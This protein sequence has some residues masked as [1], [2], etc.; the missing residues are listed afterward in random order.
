M[1]FTKQSKFPKD[2]V[3]LLGT[4][5]DG[6]SPKKL[7][8]FFGDGRSVVVKDGMK[9]KVRIVRSH[10]SG[11]LRA[12]GFPYDQDEVYITGVCRSTHSIEVWGHSFQRFC[13]GYFELIGIEK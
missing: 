5:F 6:H 7:E 2:T 13:T 3:Q 8:I 12:Y 11:Y 10:V 9:V 4:T 1:Q